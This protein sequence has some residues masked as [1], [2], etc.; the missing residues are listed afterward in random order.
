LAILEEASKIKPD[1]VVVPDEGKKET[2][3]PQEIAPEKRDD[4]L[5]VFFLYLLIF[6][7]KYFC[8]LQVDIP[9]SIKKP[10]NNSLASKEQNQNLLDLNFG[11]SM[12]SISVGDLAE[13]VEIDSEYF[14]NSWTNLHEGSNINYIL[15]YVKISI[16]GQR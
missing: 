4:L 7:L 8:L 1:D 6:L 9:S 13:A 14:Q 5:D 11:P 10:E 16:L 2:E 12:T 3:N 15:I